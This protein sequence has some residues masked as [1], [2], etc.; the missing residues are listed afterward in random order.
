L[1][2]AVNDEMRVLKVGIPKGS[3]TDSTVDLFQ[4]AGFRLS[5]S[6]RGYYP[7]I[8]DPE[9]TCVMF[10]AQEMSRYVEDG[11]LDAGLTG[12]DWICENGS[13]VHE[14]CELRY[15]K[16]TSRPARWVL[17]VPT[18]SKARSARD[19]DGG[20][21]ATELV[22]VTRRHFESLGL[23]VR[24]EFSWGAT[25]VKAR[26]VDGIVELTETGSSLAANNLRIIDEIMASTTRFIANRHAWNDPWKREKIES[27]ALLLRGAIEARAKVGLKLN[28]PRKELKQILDLLPSELSPT[29]SSLAD[30]KFVAVEVI[31][32]AVTERELVPQLQRAGASGIIVYPLNKVIP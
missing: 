6:S 23:N 8:D 24:T 29:I 14:V 13:E 2:N 18:E 21:V 5:I 3:L 9:L 28:V 26:L 31:L 11:V 17:A 25:E 19:L 12:H 32:E 20:I 30:D 15:S 7:S 22:N 16:A 4:R 27:L 1:E 10:R